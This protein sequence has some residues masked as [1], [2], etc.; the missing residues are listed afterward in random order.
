MQGSELDVLLSISEEQY[1]KI[2]WI[3]IEVTD[4]LLYKN[5]ASRKELKHFLENRG[6]MT[7]GTVNAAAITFG[8]MLMWYYLDFPHL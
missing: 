6:F 8:I 7:K 5:Q 3:Y 2:K 4:F 1:T